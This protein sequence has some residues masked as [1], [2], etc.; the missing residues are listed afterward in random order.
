M[1]RRKQFKTQGVYPKLK[2]ITCRTL[3]LALLT[4]MVSVAAQDADELDDGPVDHTSEEQPLARYVDLQPEFVLNYGRDG[5]VRFLRMEVNLVTSGSDGPAILNHHSPTLR[6]IIVLNISDAPH[7]ELN[8]TDG[9]RE[10]R[11]RILSEMQDFIRSE[12]G[13]SHVEGILFSNLVLQ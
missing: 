1:I 10:L 13:A 5:R 2:S 3:L 9:R 8:T 12:T 6:H 11:Q 4:A 7:A